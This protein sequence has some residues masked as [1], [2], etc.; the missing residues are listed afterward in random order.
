[1]KCPHCGKAIP[2]PTARQQEAYRLVH[3]A[4]L[5]HEAAGRVL[6]VSQQA[7]TAR[8]VNLAKARPELFDIPQAKIN[9]KTVISL[10]TNRD[11]AFRAKF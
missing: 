6:G 9:W 5:T 8:L 7:V 10:D 11:C 4:G 2:M 1:M 3:I